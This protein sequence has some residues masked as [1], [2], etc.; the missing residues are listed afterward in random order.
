[1]FIKLTKPD[2][3]TKYYNVEYI[4][5]IYKE[6]NNYTV[7]E[8]QYGTDIVKEHPEEIMDMIRRD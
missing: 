7:I 1:M 4:R 3:K 5:S 6:E 2:G 8:L